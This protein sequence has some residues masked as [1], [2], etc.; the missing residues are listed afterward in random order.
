MNNTFCDGDGGEDY[1][2]FGI[3]EDGSGLKLDCL[4]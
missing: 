1:L 4:I 3:L 2:L